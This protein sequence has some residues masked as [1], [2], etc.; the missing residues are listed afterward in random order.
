MKRLGKAIQNRKKAPHPKIVR[1][2]RLLQMFNKQDMLNAPKS[3]TI[4]GL[5]REKRDS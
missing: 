2:N 5:M 3:S 4:E 1:R